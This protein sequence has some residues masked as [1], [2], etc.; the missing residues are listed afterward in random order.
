MGSNLHIGNL[1]TSVTV[2][3]LREM[4]GKIGP[5]ETV[6]IMTNSETGL[7]R[8]I[9]YVR[10]TNAADAVTAI[11]RLNFTQQEG[12]VMSVSKDLRTSG[13]QR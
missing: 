9:G 3:D 10:M 6:R 11:S 12:Q 4:F 2:A 8:G 13:D 7:S 1:T 5:V